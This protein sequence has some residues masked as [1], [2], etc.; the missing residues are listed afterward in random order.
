MA[1]A[2]K[3]ATELRGHV[4]AED[5]FRVA[6]NPGVKRNPS[7]IW[8]PLEQAR[9]QIAKPERTDI[10]PRELVRQLRQFSRA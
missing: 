3:L 6:D 5:K 4:T 9:V 10:R 1:M 8:A 7:G 2:R